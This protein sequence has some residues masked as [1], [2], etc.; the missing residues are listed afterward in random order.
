[1][2]S[3][4]KIEYL[5]K[6]I[7]QLY[8]IEGRSKSYIAQLLDVNRKEL[9]LKL[10]HEWKL[11]RAQKR[12]LNPSNK[13]F[14]NKHKNLIIARLQNNVSLKT[15][16][17]ELGV[18]SSYLRDT[19][20]ITDEVLAEEHRLNQERIKALQASLRE[21]NRELLFKEKGFI[22]LPG[23]IWEQV[24]GNPKYFISNKGR[25][26][27]YLMKEDFYKLLSP[28]SN[29]KNKYRQFK[30]PNG[31]GYKIHR[32]VAFHFI[33]PAPEGKNTVNHIDGDVLNNDVSNLEWCSQA[34]NNQ[35]A[36]D[37]GKAPSIG[38][39]KIGR[40]KELHLEKD[41]KVYKFKS[42]EAMSKFLGKSGTQTSR[43]IYGES[44]FP[45]KI[46]IKY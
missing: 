10:N 44:K 19:I 41:G 1:M 21:E 26:K 6:T 35:K 2:T 12:H 36:Y 31:R 5:R 25:L 20:I 28:Q 23:E 16:S 15:I 42:I 8:C 39:S 45:H 37:A 7:E 22:D 11:E 3:Q 24:A 40:F 14:Q 29:L 18:S 17:E 43:Y 38:Y 4:E 33:G 9:G 30:F 27:R 13:K 34:E 46:S 32:L